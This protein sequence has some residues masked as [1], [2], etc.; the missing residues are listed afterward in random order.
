MIAYEAPN[1]YESTKTA[2][3]V[4][5]SSLL[6]SIFSTSYNVSLTLPTR[7][8][9]NTGLL[10]TT[11]SL[12]ES[13]LDV[14]INGGY[15]KTYDGGESE[16]IEISPN[17]GSSTPDLPGRY[18]IKFKGSGDKFQNSVREFVDDARRF[19]VT[20]VGFND[21]KAGI[22]TARE[23]FNDRLIDGI[24]QV[25]RLLDEGVPSTHILLDGHGDSVATN[26]AKHFHDRK[27]PVYLWIDRA[28]SSLVV[29]DELQD[30][31]NMYEQINAA[32]KGYMYVSKKACDGSG[33]GVIPHEASLHRAVKQDALEMRHST[34]HKVT[35]RLGTA[36]NLPRIQLFGC[37]KDYG[38]DRQTIFQE[39]V[40]THLDSPRI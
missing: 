27:R 33:D 23:K 39:F 12:L 15:V 3:S 7:W 31:A 17:L 28:P 24:A 21:R 5:F 8:F 18:I 30:L 19:N 2:L 22:R 26:V 36:H 10:R 6:R 37:K 40:E 11:I 13:A 38:K 16:T 14:N 29:D 35:A 20:V 32:Y 25:Q 9:D 1:P 4:F 34:G